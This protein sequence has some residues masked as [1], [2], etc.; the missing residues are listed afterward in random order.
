MRAPEEGS[1]LQ[2]CLLRSL[3][4]PLTQLP[5]PV[6]PATALLPSYDFRSMIDAALLAPGT[7]GTKEGPKH[8]ETQYTA[9]KGNR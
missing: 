8:V 1:L 4:L 7:R 5:L 6:P 9:R 2:H 3:L